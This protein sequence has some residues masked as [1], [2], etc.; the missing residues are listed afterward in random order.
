M[1]EKT[2]LRKQARYRALEDAAN[3][4]SEH[5]RTGSG[6]QFAFYSNQYASKEMIKMYEAE[7]RS[8]VSQLDR[9][10]ERII[11]DFQRTDYDPRRE[12]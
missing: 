1:D 2:A 11:E 5:M 10:K 4:I 7:L 12:V 6:T 8:L 3:A 9:R